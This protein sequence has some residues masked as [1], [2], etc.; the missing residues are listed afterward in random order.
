MAMRDRAW[1]LT[2]DRKSIQPEVRVGA[3]ESSQGRPP[4]KDL[5]SQLVNVFSSLGYSRRTLPLLLPVSRRPSCRVVQSCRWAASD[6]FANVSGIFRPASTLTR[7]VSS[8][9]ILERQKSDHRLRRVD[10][11]R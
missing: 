8:A 5:L 4:L 11:K 3:D 1:S 7:R 9:D 6:R 2:V 10:P